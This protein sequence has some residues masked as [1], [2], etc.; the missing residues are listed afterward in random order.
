MSEKLKP[1]P[2][3]GT[4]VSSFD[5]LDYMRC[6]IAYQIDCGGCR[7]T[8]GAYSTIEKAVDAWNRRTK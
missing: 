7:A 5:I 2:F 1:C 4:E 3:C 8:S 6:P